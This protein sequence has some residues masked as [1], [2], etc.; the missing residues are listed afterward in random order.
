MV[1]TNAPAAQPKNI[2]ER[3][4]ALEQRSEQLRQRL[5]A[6]QREVQEKLAPYTPPNPVD[7]HV[8][9]DERGLL[10]AVQLTRGEGATPAQV[11]GALNQAVLTARIRHPRLPADAVPL[12]LT[13]LRRG[14]GGPRTEVSD[15]FKQLTVTAQFGDVIQITGTD[16]W[17][18]TTPDDVIASEVLRVGRLAAL[19]SD[20]FG[21][22]TPEED[23]THG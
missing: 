23:A 4:A 21:R 13:A 15:G 5:E 16:S 17:L 22:F 14:E 19:E 9:L 6:T 18:S 7:A 12:L 2:L 3:F 20:Q 11:R 10:A 8:D 1:V